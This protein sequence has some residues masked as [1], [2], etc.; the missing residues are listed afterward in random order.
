M[1]LLV[2]NLYTPKDIVLGCVKNRGSIGRG[3]GGEVG[4]AV[5]EVLLTGPDES[6]CKVTA[7]RTCM[8]ARSCR[9]G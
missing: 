5:R 1:S 3:T 8:L 6:P 2:G 9:I 4:H 7:P